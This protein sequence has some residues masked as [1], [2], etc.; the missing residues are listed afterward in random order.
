MKCM[1][2]ISCKD[3]MATAEI[4]MATAE[5]FMVPQKNAY[6]LSVKVPFENDLPP[7]LAFLHS[8]VPESG[9]VHMSRAIPANRADL[10]HENLYFSIT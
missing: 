1:S 2:R 8:D 10:S 6:R 3:A 5:T 4:A 9:A 7:P